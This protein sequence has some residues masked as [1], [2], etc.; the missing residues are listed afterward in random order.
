MAEV[1]I[2]DALERHEFEIVKIRG[3]RKTYV[4]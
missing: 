3:A 1:S 4:Y 2:E